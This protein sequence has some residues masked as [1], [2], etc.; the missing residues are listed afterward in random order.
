VS[1]GKLVSF[2]CS[3]EYFFF[4]VRAF[5]VSISAD[6][7]GGCVRKS[8]EE[9][10]CGARSGD[11][12]VRRD[13]IKLMRDEHNLSTED[14]VVELSSVPSVSSCNHPMSF[15]EGSVGPVGTREQGGSLR[16]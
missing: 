9:W 12:V 10:D 11:D 4:E 13:W 14:S 2:F 16:S 3:G 5:F 6:V 1:R 8:S 7:Q 15:F